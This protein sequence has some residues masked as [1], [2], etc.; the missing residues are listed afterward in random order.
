MWIYSKQVLEFIANCVNF[1]LESKRLFRVQECHFSSLRSLNLDHR[2]VTRVSK[3]IYFFQWRQCTSCFMNIL[4]FLWREASQ[5]VKAGKYEN[6]GQFFM[7]IFKNWTAPDDPTKTADML[8]YLARII[9]S[10]FQDGWT[11]AYHENYISF[12][13]TSLNYR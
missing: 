7:L 13:F 6:L 5:N 8:W 3:S 9:K 1:Q 12:L 2:W 10:Y 4:H 11:S